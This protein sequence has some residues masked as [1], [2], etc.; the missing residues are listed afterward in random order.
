MMLPARLRP[1]FLC[2]SFSRYRCFVLHSLSRS[3]M[4]LCVCELTRARF[5]LLTYCCNLLYL[6]LTLSGVVFYVEA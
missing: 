6:F 2:F 4:L 3:F 5:F 1:V